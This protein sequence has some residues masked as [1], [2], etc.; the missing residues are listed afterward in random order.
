M[1]T[2]LLHATKQMLVSHNWPKALP[3]VLWE[4]CLQGCLE[5]LQHFGSDLTTS[6]QATSLLLLSWGMKEVSL[7]K[8]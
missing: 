6:G 3:Q 8:L 5:S 4:I 2:Y 7:Q 1:D